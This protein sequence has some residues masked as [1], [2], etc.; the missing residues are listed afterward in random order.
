MPNAEQATIPGASHVLHSHNP[1][2][3]NDVVLAFLARH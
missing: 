1:Q 2:A 3:H